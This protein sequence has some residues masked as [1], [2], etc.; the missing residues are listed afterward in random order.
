MFLMNPTVTLTVDLLMFTAWGAFGYLFVAIDTRLSHNMATWGIALVAAI[1]AVSK[2]FG[3][4]SGAFMWNT[5]NAVFAETDL[6]LPGAGRYVFR[7][8]VFGA[9]AAAASTWWSSWHAR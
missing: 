7:L 6:E 2:V 9:L 5:V 3:N 4:L 1:V 8:I